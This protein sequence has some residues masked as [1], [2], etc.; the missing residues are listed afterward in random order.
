MGLK[1]VNTI[2]RVWIVILALAFLSA[3][4]VDDHARGA[5]AP[6]KKVKV[7]DLTLVVPGTWKQ[8]PPSNR[9]R[10]AQFEIPAS[11]NDKEPAELS[12]FNF[13][14]GGGVEQQVERWKGQFLPAKRV[15][16]M[17]QGKIE[18]GEYVLVNLAGTY[19]KPTG[20]PVLRQTKSMPGAEMLVVM[21]RTEKGTYFLKLIGLKAT[22]SAASADFRKAIGVPAKKPAAAK[23]KPATP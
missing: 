16:S 11:G 23:E 3:V 9:L 6:T 19:K 2:S 12:V 13:G 4:V 5:D 21:I 14:A 1:P 20:P 15:F 18:L 7:G 8:Q 10:L 17:E 22:V